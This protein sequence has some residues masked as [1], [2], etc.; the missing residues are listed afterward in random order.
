MSTVLVK[1]VKSGWS[2]RGAGVA[3]QESTK[4]EK[5]PVGEWG[6]KGRARES[7]ALI[8]SLEVS[9]DGLSC[10]Q[11]CVAPSLRH[12][13]EQEVYHLDTSDGRPLGV[14]RCSVE[15]TVTGDTLQASKENQLS[16]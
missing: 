4:R 9:L 7:M 14:S 3:R 11:R 1:A 2:S 6:K 10:L 16:C 5:S 8:V 12:L 13:T 15:D